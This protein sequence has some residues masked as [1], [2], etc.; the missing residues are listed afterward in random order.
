MIKNKIFLIGFFFTILLSCDNFEK[1]KNK[2]FEHIGIYNYNKL[3]SISS[4]WLE[5]TNG[6]AGHR[7]SENAYYLVNSMK[8]LKKSSLNTKNIFNYLGMPYFRRSLDVKGV[9]AT[10]YYYCIECKKKS[11]CYHYFSITLDS[12]VDTVMFIHSFIH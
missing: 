9:N 7:N 11:P 12:Q 8:E 1:N 3:D 2:S 5:D 4:I 10:Q 6:C